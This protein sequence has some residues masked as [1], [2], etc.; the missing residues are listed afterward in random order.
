VTAAAAA[1]AGDADISHYGCRRWRLAGSQYYYK[2]MT[3]AADAKG[4]Q[5]KPCN[6]PSIPCNSAPKLPLHNMLR[7]PGVSYST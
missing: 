4:R 3:A 6:R 7:P 5:S 1:A 2:V